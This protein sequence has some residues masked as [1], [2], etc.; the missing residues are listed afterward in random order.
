MPTKRTRDRVWENVIEKVIRE[1]QS[2][3][4]QEIAKL[5]D[6]S[7]RTARECL[8]VISETPFLNRELQ[9]DGSVRFTKSP[10]VE[11]TG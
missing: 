8:N 9:S 5:S 4:P 7:E 10:D 6:V 11:F 2:V 3:T 1:E